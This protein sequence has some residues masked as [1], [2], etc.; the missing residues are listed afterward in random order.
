LGAI[1]VRTAV[2][3]APSLLFPAQQPIV[4]GYSTSVMPL[5]SD[6]AVR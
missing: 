1:A 3:L 2:A 4:N 5:V 6:F